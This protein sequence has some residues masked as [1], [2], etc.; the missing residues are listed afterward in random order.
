MLRELL[1]WLHIAIILAAV[2]TGFFLPLPAIIGLV[3]LHRLHMVFFKGCA[4]SRLQ[5]R[6]NALPGHLTFLQLAGKKVF[7]K[8]LSRIQSYCIDGALVLIPISTTIIR[9]YI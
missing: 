6:L 8:N 7:K 4:F 9:Q 1:F 3:L 2:S 5:K